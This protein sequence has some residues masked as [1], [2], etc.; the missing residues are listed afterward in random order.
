MSSMKYLFGALVIAALSNAAEP[1]AFAQTSAQTQIDFTSKLTPDNATFV[2][3][4]FLEGFI[5][6]INT[7]E[8][9]TFRRNAEAYARLTDIFDMPTIMLGDEGGFRGNF[10]PEV[11]A[12]TTHAE[13]IERHVVSAWDEPAFRDAIERIGRKKIVLGG[14]SIDICTLQ[15]ALDLKSAGYEPY[16]VVDVS[17]S[18]TYLNEQ[19]SI[20]R[21]QQAGIVVTNWGSVASELMVDWNSEEGEAIGMLYEE[22]SA[23]GRRF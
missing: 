22:Y 16:V 8:A 20:F 15:L 1:V 11:A 9:R 5:P 4:D 10:L 12:Y 13:R 17:G 7:I 2:M 14:P 19:A 3:V 21:L 18:D 23:W 6:G